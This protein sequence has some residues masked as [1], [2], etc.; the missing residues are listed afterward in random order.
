M[1]KAAFLTVLS[2]S[3]GLLAFAPVTLALDDEPVEALQA[4]EEIPDDRLLDVGI[5]VFDTGIPDDEEAKA[6]L[7]EKGIFEDIRKSEARW[8]PMN[9][10]RT[11][12]STG[13]WGAVRLVP[14]ASSVDVIVDGAIVSSTG[15]KL[16]I[17]VIVFDATGRSWFSKRYKREADPLAYEEESTK[18]P[19]QSLYNQI[20]NDLLNERNDLDGEDFAGIQK[21][22]HLK[23]AK[24]LAPIAFQD[25][26]TVKKGR[27]YPVRLPAD[28]DPMMARVSEIRERDHMF[29]DTLNEYYADLYS[30]ME[31]PYRGWRSNSY[32]EQLALDE[33]NKAAKWR[34]I[35]GAAAIF[36]GIMAS[37]EGRGWSNAGEVAILGGMA[38]VMDGFDKSAQAK[39]NREAL[40]ELAASFDSEVEELL[41]DV[42]GEVHR[43]KGSVETQYASWRQLLR[44]IFAAETGIAVDLDPN[45]S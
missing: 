41:I 19:F 30:K 38:A 3:L 21:V 25:Y 13:Y 40:K 15:K 39:M 33:L 22:A 43:L 14:S 18:E 4:L 16:E 29:I 44:D 28:S 9:L 7:E 36:G 32:E 11:L 6:F 20:A 8:I 2:S 17:D 12:E 31:T 34:K 45:K 35:L 26:L 5:H 10:K 37:R 42:E 23:F 27:Y 1:T 24:D